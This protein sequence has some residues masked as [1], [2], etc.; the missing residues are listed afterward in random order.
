MAGRDEVV[1]GVE[2][3][4][5]GVRGGGGDDPVRGRFFDVVGGDVLADGDAVPAKAVDEVGGH[6]GGSA[7]WWS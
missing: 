4:E 1:E 2:G 7:E 6:G 5:E 3:V